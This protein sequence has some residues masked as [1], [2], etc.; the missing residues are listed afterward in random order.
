[1]A[2]LPSGA[3]L[4]LKA[5]RVLVAGD[6]LVGEAST[7]RVDRCDRGLRERQLLVVDGEVLER[8]AGA[9]GALNRGD[10]AVGEKQ[11]GVLEIQRHVRGAVDSTWVFA[12]RWERK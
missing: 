8:H 4:A 11:I 9:I 10:V 2:S 5:A 1:M 12:L 7:G 6:R 3:R